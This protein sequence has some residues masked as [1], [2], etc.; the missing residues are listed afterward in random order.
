M[1]MEI[2]PPQ[3]SLIDCKLSYNQ[4]PST[5]C[6]L[7]YNKND[8]ASEVVDAK[9]ETLAFNCVSIL[10]KIVDSVEKT[11]ISEKNVISS[12]QYFKST[13]IPDISLN[14]YLNRL[15]KY[16]DFSDTVLIIA[17]KNIFRIYRERGNDFPINRLSI[18]RLM[19]TNIMVAAK[20]FDDSFYSNSSYSEVG[21][22]SLKEINTLERELL[23]LIHFDLSIS[24]EE[25]T[26]T[27]SFIMTGFNFSTDMEM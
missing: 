27:K 2:T 20:F 4:S 8:S 1:S 21:G 11:K 24:S 19:L 3:F 6:K 22:V 5:D 15:I 13:R 12:Y 9:N 18:H 14:A 16:C 26:A 23:N 25:F 17:M 7:S 10:E